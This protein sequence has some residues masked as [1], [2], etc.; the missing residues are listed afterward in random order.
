MGFLSGIFGGGG[1]TVTQTAKNTTEIT[2]TNQIANL[3]DLEALADAVKSM[4]DTVGSAIGSVSDQTQTLF[5]GLLAQLGMQQQ[6]TIL[7]AVA[8]AQETDRQNDLAERFLNM[9]KIA[10]FAV[11][12]YFVW[13][14]IL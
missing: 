3:I 4:G 12:A 5:T 11:A 13:R 2:L 14:K 10:G 9:L 1:T 8:Q 7:T 6:A